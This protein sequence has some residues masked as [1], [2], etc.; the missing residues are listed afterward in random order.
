MITGQQQRLLLARALYAQPRVL[1][2]DEATSA[3]DLGTQARVNDNL[4]QLG[5]TRVMVAHRQETLNMADRVVDLGALVQQG[6]QL[7]MAAG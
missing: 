6:Q 2:L 4:K 5:T 7:R 1:F 3:L